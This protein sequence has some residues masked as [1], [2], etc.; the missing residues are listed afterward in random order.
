MGR[1]NTRKSLGEKEVFED[2]RYDNVTYKA[3]IG[4]K[5]CDTKIIEKWIKDKEIL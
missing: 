1:Y 5:S 2:M 3:V 4:R